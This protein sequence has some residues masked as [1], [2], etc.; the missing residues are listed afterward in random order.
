MAGAPS[1]DRRN[2]PRSWEGMLKFCLE[3][4]SEDA[5][6]QAKPMDEE[7]CLFKCCYRM[8]LSQFLILLFFVHF[9]NVSYNYMKNDQNGKKQ[10][11]R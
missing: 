2:V 7:V 9:L 3:N 4:T 6:S 5:G 8:V 10:L 11:T 1:D